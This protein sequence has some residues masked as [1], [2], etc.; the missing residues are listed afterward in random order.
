VSRTGFTTGVSVALEAS[1]RGVLVATH[2][3][4]SA[5]NLQAS[6]HFLNAIPNALTMEYPR[7]QQAIWQDL[8][9]PP[10]L[11]AAGHIAPPSAPGLGIAP[12]PLVMQQSLVA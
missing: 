2:S 1:R 11:N 7:L 6:L 5:F 10:G 12:D 8:A 9:P 4:T 3:Q